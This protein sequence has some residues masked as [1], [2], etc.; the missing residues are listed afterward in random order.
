MEA[1]EIIDLIK[2]EI[3]EAQVRLEDVR[4]DGNHYALTVK[5]PDFRGRSLADQ[6]RMVFMALGGRVG[7]I[8]PG[9][10]LTTL[11]CA[12]QDKA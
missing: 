1:Q 2:K 7:G 12:P 11:V 4:G 6:H 5:A 10:T 3:P 9:V 8:L